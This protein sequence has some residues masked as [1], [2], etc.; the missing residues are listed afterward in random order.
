MKKSAQV[1]LTVVAAI[2]MASCS[3]RRDPC[4]AEYFSEAVCQEAVRDGGYHYGGTWYPM[5]YSYPYPYY[6]D[7]YR[8]HV[9]RGGMVRS[10]PAGSYSRPSVSST[11]RGGFGSIGSG[12]SS[13][14]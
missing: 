1:T 6:Y 2:G 4:Q 13:G 9:S 7:G 5:M 10:A 14:S 12:H 11:P 3:R 8:S